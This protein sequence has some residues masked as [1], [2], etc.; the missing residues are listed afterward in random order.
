MTK[1]SQKTLFLGLFLVLFSAVAQ[2]A[3]FVRAGTIH[4]LSEFTQGKS[5]RE[6]FDTLIKD[7]N[8]VVDFYAS[9]CGPCKQMKPVLEALAKD[10]NNVIFLKINIEQFSQISDL[11]N[12]RSIPTLIFFRKG[13]QVTRTTGSLGKAK[14]AATLATIYRS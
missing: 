6:A 10:F 13:A 3:T 5:V 11:Y 7:N 9:W 14:L 12:I 1:N 8:V 4:D 2:A